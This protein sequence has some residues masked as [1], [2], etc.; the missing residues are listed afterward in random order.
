MEQSKRLKTNRVRLNKK[1]PLGF[2]LK[3][4]TYFARFVAN[5]N[6]IKFCKIFLSVLGR[7]LCVINFPVHVDIFVDE[8]EK[9]APY[10]EI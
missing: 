7:K 8:P 10:C 3:K 1:L 6:L 2:F 5:S 9:V 4:S